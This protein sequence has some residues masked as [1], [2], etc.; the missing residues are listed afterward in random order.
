[1]T[2]FITGFSLII[3]SLCAPYRPTGGSIFAFWM[4]VAFVF[5]SFI[6][7]VM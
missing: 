7:G 6:K 3:L 4:G 5:G 2:P 1:M